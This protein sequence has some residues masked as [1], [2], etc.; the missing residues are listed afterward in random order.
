LEER[1]VGLEPPSRTPGQ[2]F[3]TETPDLEQNLAVAKIRAWHS[4]AITELISFRGDLTVVVSRE[5][6]RP[7]TEFLAGDKELAY[8]FL[9]DVTAV[10]R[11][12]DEPRFSLPARSPAGKFTGHR[13][14]DSRLADGQLARARNF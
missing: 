4:T 13:D 9:S 3:V 12:P 2:R 6:L 10:D 1:G 14:R 8:T 7:L 11:F 5:Q